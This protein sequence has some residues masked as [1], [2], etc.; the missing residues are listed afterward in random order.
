M[1]LR[2]CAKMKFVGFLQRNIARRQAGPGPEGDYLLVT[3]GGGGDGAD[4]IHDVIHAYQ[5]DRTYAQGIDRARALYA[6]EGASSSTGFEDTADRDHRIRQSGW[7]IWWRVQK[8]S[9]PWA[10]TTP[11]CEIL[12][13]DKPALIVPRVKPREGNIRAPR[14]ETRPGRDAFAGGG[15]R[16]QR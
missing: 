14:V 16:V 5:H 12:S 1:F 10:A 7:R 8:P 6:G 9:S 15:G 3:T 4:L 13:F 2:L 11:C